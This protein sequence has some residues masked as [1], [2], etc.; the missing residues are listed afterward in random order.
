MGEEVELRKQTA[1]K[2]LEVLDVIGEV[3]TFTVQYFAC[4][5][6]FFLRLW[7]QLLYLNRYVNSPSHCLKYNTCHSPTISLANLLIFRYLWC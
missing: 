1:D 2:K 4:L 7:P 3:T 6:N 5:F